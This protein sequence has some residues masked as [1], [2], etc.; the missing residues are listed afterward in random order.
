MLQNWLEIVP[1]QGQ[2]GRIEENT[3][4]AQEALRNKLW[5]RGDAAE[6][7]QYYKQTEQYGYCTGARFW[8][9]V[10]ETESVRK[11]HSG[12]PAMIVDTLAYI[13]KADMEQVDFGEDTQA[14][15]KWEQIEADFDFRALVGKA[16]R[17]TLVTGDG[18][19]KISVDTDLS[20]YPIVE[21]VSGDRVDYI[22]KRGRLCGVDFWTRRCGDKG[23][24]SLRERYEPGRVSYALFDGD[25]EVPL[26]RAEECKSLRPV[27]F[28]GDYLMA[29]PLRIFDNPRFY[30]RGKSVF[31]SKTDVFDAHDEVISQWMDAIRAGRVQ[32]Y[33]PEDMIPRDPKTGALLTPNTFG[34]HFVALEANAKEGVA[35]KIDTIQPEIR[36]D[37]FLS[38]YSATL[39]MCLQGV[40]SPATLGIDV[41]RMASGEAQR[42]KKDVTGYTRNAIT[43]AL[44]KTLPVL[45]SAVLKTY[46]NMLD[47]APEEYECTVSFG[48]YGAPD[49]DSRIS[50]VAAASG[51]DIMSIESQVDELWGD[52]K[53]AEWKAA[54]VERIKRLRGIEAESEPA[55]GGDLIDSMG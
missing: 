55:V 52:S 51:A 20:D 54:E 4:F 27:E 49:F 37:A 42:E 3:T 12:L 33:I 19:F 28:C 9:A 32:K 16:I 18:A 1:A 47:Q 31:D 40:L 26:D 7:E 29:V 2:R 45:V 36:Y 11:I 13:V 6:I 48:E 15:G 21:F 41:G 5:Y 17:E 43:D 44:E 10:P 35:S 24:Y 22:I 50:T 23:K 30:G 25:K 46:D 34:S 38:T 39:N 8:A 14:A 53:D